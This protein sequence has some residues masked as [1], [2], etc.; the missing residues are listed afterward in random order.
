MLLVVVLLLSGAGCSLATWREVS[1]F[2]SCAGVRLVSVS[3]AGCSLATWLDVSE[4]PSCAG[5]WL[6]SLVVTG[7]SFG[8]SPCRSESYELAS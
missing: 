2:L 3:V 6:V 8:W 7:C 1:E 5:G 4:F